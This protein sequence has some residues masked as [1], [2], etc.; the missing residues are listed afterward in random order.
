[1]RRIIIHPGF[2][3]TGTTGLQETLRANRHILRPDIRLVLRPGMEALCDMARNYSETREDFDLDLVKYEATAL[4]ESLASETAQTIVITSRDI[5]G[6]MPGRRGL[7]GYGAVPKLMQAIASAFLATLPRDELLFF[8]TTR[9][10]DA[11]LHRSY[12]QHL[13]NSRL[14]L[15][16]RDYMRRFKTAA[17]FPAAIT[18]ID[19]ALPRYRVTSAAIED[20][21]KRPLGLADAI[22]DL[23]GVPDS[24]R[25]E[26]EIKQ[27]QSPKTAARMRAKLLELNRS[28]LPAAALREAKQ[29]LLR[30]RT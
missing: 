16:L 3:K 8:I 22:L 19:E 26:L 28:D 18:K 14:P 29:S 17:D 6:H 9:Q 23:A 13:R 1:M 25:A 7:H 2:H 24:R 5:S 15:D 11:W 27:T 10:P 30:G 12:D 20:H 4:A 21:A